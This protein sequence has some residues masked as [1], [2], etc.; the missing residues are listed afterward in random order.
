MQPYG[1]KV[2]IGTIQINEQM[3]A[4]KSSHRHKFIVTRLPGNGN[5]LIGFYVTG[6]YVNSIRADLW[7]KGK[8]FIYFDSYNNEVIK[9]HCE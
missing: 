5:S 8:P 2:G 4:A 3:G 6:P 1:T 9:G 7:K